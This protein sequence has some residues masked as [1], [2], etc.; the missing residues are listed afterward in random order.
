M[1]NKLYGP[2]AFYNFA[3]LS[4]CI[5]QFHNVQGHFQDIPKITISYLGETWKNVS[6]STTNKLVIY[7]LQGDDLMMKCEASNPIQWNFTGLVSPPEV[8][9]IQ[10]PK[11]DLHKKIYEI[12]VNIFFWDAE[13]YPDLGA[14]V[15]VACENRGNHEVRDELFVIVRGNNNSQLLVQ[16]KTTTVLDSMLI[17]CATKDPSLVPA[18]FMRNFQVNNLNIYRVC[19]V[20]TYHIYICDIF[21]HFLGKRRNGTRWEWEQY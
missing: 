8:V 21:L 9:K 17:P 1:A 16:P 10:P 5:F 15:R 18:L 11:V 6:T 7:S 12:S 4:S 19:F 14:S 20:D 13:K 2:V 3:I